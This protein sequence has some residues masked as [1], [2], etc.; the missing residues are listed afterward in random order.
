[1]GEPDGGAILEGQKNHRLV[2][3]K[4]LQEAPRSLGFARLAVE[5]TIRIEKRDEEIQVRHCRLPE[6]NSVSRHTSLL[7]LDLAAFGKEPKRSSPASLD[8][9]TP[10]T[11]SRISC[12]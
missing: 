4:T 7:L 3:L 8:L 5:L 6:I 9:P 11:E 1:L 12:T 2:V 10:A